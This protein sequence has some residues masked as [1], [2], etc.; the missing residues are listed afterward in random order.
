MNWTSKCY[1]FFGIFFLLLLVF[2]VAPYFTSSQ[3]LANRLDI[4]DSDVEN[5]I[6]FLSF[7]AIAAF[8]LTG[9]FCI[10]SRWIRGK[11]RQGSRLGEILISLGLITQADL[12]KA[13]E[14]QNLKI[15]EI[16]VRSGLISAGQRDYA[17]MIQRKDDHRLGEIMQQLGFASERDIQWA[18]KMKN[19]RLGVILQQVKPITDSD[20]DYA[21]N[22][23]NISRIDKRGQINI[24]GL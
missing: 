20:I 24:D 5:F 14:Q 4:F 15:G 18:L 9:L 21:L 3:S 16:L 23:K 22:I 10:A 12:E 1:L 7:A 8:M 19:R 17:L 2:F 13:L 6:F 11:R